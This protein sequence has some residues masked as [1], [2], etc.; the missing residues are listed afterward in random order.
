M[1]IQVEKKDICSIG[2][3][4]IPSEE[5]NLIIF[6]DE[7]TAY[8]EE[9]FIRSILKCFGENYE[10]IAT[11]EYV[12]GYNDDK[13]VYTVFITNLPYEKYKNIID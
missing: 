4:H 9:I 1:N 8:I 7:M 3:N 6:C 10:I 13:E 5:G 2:I 12:E 11:E